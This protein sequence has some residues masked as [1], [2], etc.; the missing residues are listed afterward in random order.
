MGQKQTVRRL[1]E[2][3]STSLFP[4]RF[5]FFRKTPL[6]F[7]L[8]SQSELF[9]LLATPI[10]YDSPSHS[11]PN[12]NSVMPSQ[13]GLDLEAPPQSYHRSSH[14]PIL[15]IN[16]AKSQA[17]CYLSWTFFGHKPKNWCV[18]IKLYFSSNDIK[19][20]FM[21]P[22][23]FLPRQ[24]VNL[25][26]KVREM[27]SLLVYFEHW[28]TLPGHLSLNVLISSIPYKE[29]FDLV[30]HVDFWLNTDHNC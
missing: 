16:Y 26:N 30:K 13:G 28:I 22:T 2:V 1:G 5:I 19:H 23:R 27:H 9:T 10:N 4:N 29:P 25:V 11:P 24:I 20:F 18:R 8:Q 21:L 6:F 3:H 14:Y 17:M 12:K 15:S 7:L